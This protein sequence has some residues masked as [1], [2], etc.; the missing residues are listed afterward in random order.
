MI[1]FMIVVVISFLISTF[2]YQFSQF[3]QEDVYFD[4]HM[5]VIRNTTMND[6][7]SDS[8]ISSVVNSFRIITDR[9][10]FILFLV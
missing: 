2:L 10:E 3:I 4:I 6:L 9:K 8:S 5:M 7:N 1:Q